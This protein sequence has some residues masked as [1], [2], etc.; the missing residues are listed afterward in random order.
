MLNLTKKTLLII[1]PHPD[2]EIIGCGGLISKIKSLGG[3]VYVLYLTVGTTSDFSKRGVSTEF[4][5]VEEIKKVSSFLKLDGWRIAFPGD[6]YHLQLDRLGQKQIIH[7]IERGEKISLELLKP[8]IVA[9]P[10]LGDYNQDHSAAA[11]A[12]FSACRPASEADKFVPDLILSYE[13]PMGFWSLETNSNPNFFVKLT[14]REL[15]DKIKAV[16]LYKSQM[17]GTGYPRSREVLESLAAVRGS[18]IG[19]EFAE[20]F[21]CHKIK[22]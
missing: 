19:T 14:A 4:E 6:L 21:Y 11:R 13:A 16:S 18:I 3:K 7:E 5:R 22:V 15:G 17:R 1:A 9:F 2:D 12:T 8:D 20:G 10:C